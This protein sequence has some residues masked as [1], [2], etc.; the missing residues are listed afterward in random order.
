[1]T[2]GCLALTVRD[3][4]AGYPEHILASAAANTPCQ[5][6]GTGLGL[7]FSRVIAQSHDNRGR[8]GELRLHNDQGAVFCLLLP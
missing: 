7:Q 1:M 2:E 8:R 6:T 3:D 5:S 4:S